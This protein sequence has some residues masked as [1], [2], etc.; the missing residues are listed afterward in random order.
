MNNETIKIKKENVLAA[1][2]TARQ[3]GADSTMKMLEAMF[4][5]E[6]FKPKDITEQI[7]TFE[8]ACCELGYNHPFVIQAREIY[9]YFLDGAKESDSNDLL[10]YL[11]L[12]IICAALNEDWEVK[13]TEDECRYY[14]WFYLYTQKEL[15]KMD[16]SEKQERNIVSLNGYVSDYRGFCC[17]GSSCVPSTTDAYFGSRLCFKNSELATYC[18]RQ[19]IE[20]WMN[21]CLIRK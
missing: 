19:F 7:K 15:D 3:S 2:E 12:R 4:G 10:A 8:D 18:G 20:L 14:P 13:F 11:K 1:Y 21:F 6:T 5:K 9:D 16:E 17:A